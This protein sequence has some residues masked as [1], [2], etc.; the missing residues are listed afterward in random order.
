MKIA[1][2]VLFFLLT[3]SR[4]EAEISC[5]IPGDTSKVNSFKKWSRQD[6]LDQLAF[7]DSSTALINYY[8]DRRKKGKKIMGITGSIYAVAMVVTIIVSGTIDP[9]DGEPAALRGVFLIIPV[10]LLFM[11]LTALFGSG[12]ITRHII[13]NRKQLFKTLQN[14]KSG[15]GIPANTRKNRVYQ[16]EVL[17][18]KPEEK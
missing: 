9:G 18:E 17:A 13:F 15:K 10:A 8:F 11:G 7:D 14:Y 16:A 1:F 2:I 12:F 4:S 3:G 5:I 6:F